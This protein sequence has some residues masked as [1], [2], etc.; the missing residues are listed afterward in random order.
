M[1]ESS[2]LAEYTAML[3]K[4]G[5]IDVSDAQNAVT[6][7]VK[8]FDVDASDVQSVMDMLVEVGNNFPISVSQLAE[9]MNSRSPHGE[10][11]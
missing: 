2:A 11:G 7:I 10:C 6:A 3:S 8:A 9:G 5:D 1:Q 4:V